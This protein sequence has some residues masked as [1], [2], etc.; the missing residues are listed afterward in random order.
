MNKYIHIFLAITLLACTKSD[1]SAAP[2]VDPFP[3]ATWEDCSQEL[4]ANPCNF[5]LANQSGE[6]VSLYEFYGD[7]IVLDFSAAWCGP[8]QAAASEVQG[9]ADGYDNLSYI[10]I[11]IETEDGQ[12]P[13]TEDV[14]AWAI[15]YGLSE[16]VLAGSRDMLNGATDHS[17]NL[18]SWPTF[19][20]ITDEM[21]VHKSLSG[22]SLSYIDMLIQETMDN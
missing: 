16:P 3:F 17:W 14:S 18:S 20:F 13:T 15:E 8:C 22:Y 1:D 21:V 11:L 19:Y 2:T 12:P 5:T 9:V 7:T 6:A 10:T 4:G